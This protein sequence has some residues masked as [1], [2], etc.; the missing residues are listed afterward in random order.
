MSE[1]KDRKGS[2][3]L[4]LARLGIGRVGAP[5]INEDEQQVP[6]PDRRIATLIGMH[7]GVSS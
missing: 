7:P 3:W 4:R 2:S 6:N 5:A 1:G